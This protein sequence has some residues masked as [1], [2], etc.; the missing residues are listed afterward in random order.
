M[1]GIKELKSTYLTKPHFKG[2]KLGALF[3]LSLCVLL[4]VFYWHH[5]LGDLLL[6]KGDFVFKEGD[7]YR[8]MTSLFIHGDLGHLLFNSLM[9]MILSYFV[10]EYYGVLTFF[11]YSIGGGILT[12]VLTLNTMKPDIG[13]LGASGVVYFLWGFWLML[14]LLIQRSVTLS[15]RLMKVAAVSLFLFVP[16]SFDPQVSYMA[17]SVGLGVGLVTGVGHFLLFK[18]RL[19]SFET[20]KYTFEFEEEGAD[21]DPFGYGEV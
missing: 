2:A 21:Y 7:I 10:I 14:Y 16:S 1:E 13:L 19:R 11:F 12:N 9:L 20:Y 4:S 8:L 5:P 6:A 3:F 15:R 17:H 18:E